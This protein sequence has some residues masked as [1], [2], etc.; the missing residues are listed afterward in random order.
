MSKYA[1]IETTTVRFVHQKYR[2]PVHLQATD[3]D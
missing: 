3:A 1:I 2:L